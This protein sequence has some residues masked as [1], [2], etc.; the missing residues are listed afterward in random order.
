MLF[1]YLEE[2]KAFQKD[3]KGQ[4]RKAKKRKTRKALTVQRQHLKVMIKYL[5][6]D[7]AKVKQTLYPLLD[8]KLITFE[9]LWALFKSDD[10]AYCTTYNDANE[11][12]AFTIE[13]ANKEQSLVKGS[14]YQIEGKYL[15]YDGKT[16]GKGNISVEQ[17][18]FKGPKAITSLA[19]YPLR[20]H[21]DAKNLREKLIARGKQFVA[22]KGLNYRY[23]KGVSDPVFPILLIQATYVHSNSNEL[24]QEI[25]AI[26]HF[27]VSRTLGSKHVTCQ[28]RSRTYSTGH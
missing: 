13:F 24:C 18:S 15:E 25:H 23:H 11:P 5:D 1:M 12:R 2:M 10:I 27:N 8:A 20:Y 21:P 16:F 17:E 19:C 14:W 6:K 26:G 28:I 9:F 3:L 22:L 4:I 7:Y